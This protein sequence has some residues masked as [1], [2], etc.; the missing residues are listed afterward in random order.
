MYTIGQFAIMTKLTT[1]TLRYYDEIDLIKPVKV[2]F[3]N[4]YRYYDENSLLQAQQILIYRDCG[5]PLKEIKVIT[6]QVSSNTEGSAT[7]K[8][9][10]I[11]QRAAIDGK[12]RDVQNSRSVLQEIINSLEAEKMEEV[13]LKWHTETHALSIRERGD[14]DSIGNIIS[15]LYEKAAELNLQV[16]GAHTILWHEEKD[17]EQDSVDMEIFVPLKLEVNQDLESLSKLIKKRGRSQYCETEYEGPLS[18]VS[19]AYERIL[20]YIDKNNL[21][22]DGPFEETYNQTGKSF[23]PGKMKIVVA[24]PVIKN[25]LRH[26]G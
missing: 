9:L 25:D 13:N 2:D 11:N 14:H 20:N 10:L 16:Q 23:L 6:D 7:L 19:L 1:K 18:T 22:T 5:I 21:Q 17:F 15:R 12:I 3:T 26:R 24:V 8:E 4:N